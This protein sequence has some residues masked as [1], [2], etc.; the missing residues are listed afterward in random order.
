MKVPIFAISKNYFHQLELDKEE[1][2]VSK[3]SVENLELSMRIWLCG[4][5]ILK[6]QC[7]RIG[8]VF[9][10]TSV[11][12]KNN[13]A[14]KKLFCE[15]W[16]DEYK[17]SVYMRDPDKYS[18]IK[19]R[20]ISKI[21]KLR[22]N[23]NSFKYFMEEV[24]PEMILKYPPIVANIASGL[25]KLYM[26]DFCATINDKKVELK[27]CKDKSTQKFEMTWFLDVRYA[28]DFCL[29]IPDLTFKKC[30]TESSNQRFRYYRVSVKN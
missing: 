23:C 17:Q 21:M 13:F 26:T 19:I 7:S 11:E 16:L 20:N 18:E 28:S 8:Y 30:N 12:S 9:K 4:G 22:R 5:K 3:S 1:F 2:Q 14:D 10:D 27:Y 24:A 15:V 25:L 6:V 29:T